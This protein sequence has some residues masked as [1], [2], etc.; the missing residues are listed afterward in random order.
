MSTVTEERLDA[1]TVVCVSEHHRFGTDAFLLADFAAPRRKDTV[2]DLG[3]GCGIIPMILKKRFTP[4]KIVGV[5][6]QKEAVDLFSESILRSNAGDT[7]TAMQG[8][9]REIR[10]YLP[11]GAFDVVT[12]NPP[13]KAVGRGIMS[14]S[15][16]DQIA[17][18]E[19]LCTIE[20]VCAAAAW[21]LRFGGRCCVCQ[22]PE[23]L[24][25]VI[26]AMRAAKLEPK[27]L[28]FVAK[29]AD[30]KPWLFLI[31]GRKGGGSGMTVLPTL[32]VVENGHPTDSLLFLYG[33]HA[34]ELTKKQTEG[35]SE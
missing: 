17:R 32:T 7:I 31:E 13:Y 12:C 16:S 8:D 34:K 30:T 20:D 9:L 14:D 15:E 28:R 18:H 25:D 10:S 35:V 1:D 29:N 21:L 26:C 23:R 4:K 11:A 27:R 2:C 5:E 3:S 19:T 22:R 33:E 24:G 6:L